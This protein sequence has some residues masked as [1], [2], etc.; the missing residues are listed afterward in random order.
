MSIIITATREHRLQPLANAQQ[1]S[2]R[3]ERT[4][5]LHQ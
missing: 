2:A 3:Y 1:R 4:L 5:Q